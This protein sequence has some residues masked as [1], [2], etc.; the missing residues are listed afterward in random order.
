V[1]TFGANWTGDE[2]AADFRLGLR[3]YFT[4]GVIDH[5]GDGTLLGVEILGLLADCE[6]LEDPNT[7]ELQQ[8]GLVSVS[9]DRDADA[10]YLRVRNGRATH[11]EVRRTVVII[12]EGLRLCRVHVGAARVGRAEPTR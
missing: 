12:D 1:T 9:I 11:Q 7:E 8:A 2:L 5:E 3:S 6:G 10:I 4:D